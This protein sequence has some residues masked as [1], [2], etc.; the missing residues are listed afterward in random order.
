MNSLRGGQFDD[1]E[2]NLVVYFFRFSILLAALLT[3]APIVETILAIILPNN[4]LEVEFAIA[5]APDLAMPLIYVTIALSLLL[6]PIAF[7]SLIMKSRKL[8]IGF[9]FPS[10][11]LVLFSMVVFVFLVM[12]GNGVVTGDRNSNTNS[13]DDVDI[14]TFADDTQKKIVEFGI[15]EPGKFDELQEAESCCGLNGQAIF[16]FGLEGYNVTTFHS[17][18]QCGSV[19]NIEAIFNGN[20]GEFNEQARID[21]ND[22]DIIGGQSFFCELNFANIVRSITQDF[23]II[24]GVQGFFQIVL[25]FLF[26]LLL[27]VF[28]E[29]DG[30]F[31]QNEADIS[32]NPK[33]VNTVLVK[34]GYQNGQ[35]KVGTK[36]LSTVASRNKMNGKAKQKTGTQQV[37]FD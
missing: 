7:A 18:L 30:G 19:A 22:A 8:A 13:N 3:I 29:K 37:H 15:A 4:S 25:S 26:G 28:E 2:D 34:A 9:F 35:K 33:V 23:S 6:N 27:Y 14:I 16:G 12:A 11:L 20:N 24:F 21:I 17:G 32:A 1:E 10:L 36:T 5:V 31:R